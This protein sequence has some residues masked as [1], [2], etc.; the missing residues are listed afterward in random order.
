MKILHLSGTFRNDGASSSIINLHK[1]LIDNKINSECFIHYQEADIEEKNVYLY[2]KNKKLND[3][4]KD[5][6]ENYLIYLLKKNKNFAFFNNNFRGNLFEILKKRQFDILHIHWFPRLFDFKKLLGIKKPILFTLRDYWLLT[7]GCNYPLNCNKYENICNDCPH[8]KTKLEKD[9]SFYNFLKKREIL[10][11]IK[12]KIYIICLNKQIYNQLKKL[13]IFIKNHIYYIPN[14][15]NDEFFFKQEKIRNKS[16]KKIILFGAQNL[17][18]EWKGSDILIK[19]SKKIDSNKYS[20]LSYGKISKNLEKKIME[21][22][23]YKN[24]GIVENTKLHEIYNNSDCFLFPSKIETFGKVILEALF[25]GTPVVAFNQFAAK[26][27]ISHKINGYLVKPYDLN[28]LLIG[29]NYAINKIE[30]NK[31]ALDKIKINYGLNKIAKDYERIYSN[32]LK[33]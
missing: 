27:I 16:K 28:D 24:L 13:N 9:L 14:A 29:I 7:G 5:K 25:C 2:N 8:L 15:I 17:D 19:L 3:I 26:D 23:E 22:I 12:S 31:E 33:T 11:K 6:F 18:Q 32:I 4:I 21:N 20:L 1:K 10:K 30:F